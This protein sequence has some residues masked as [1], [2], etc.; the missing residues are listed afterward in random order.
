MDDPIPQHAYVVREIKER[1]PN[2]AFLSVVEPRVSGSQV[3]EQPVAASDSNDFLREIWK[4]KLLI[5]GGGYTRESAIQQAEKYPNELIAFGRQ[6]IS[7]PDL[8]RRL[9]E[10]LPLTKYDRST[11]YTN[12]A[13]GYIDYPFY[14]DQKQGN[15]ITSQFRVLADKL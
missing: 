4:P 12:D 8:F 1:Y 9:R 7:N 13:K 11:F 10:D 3:L 2:F 6:F 14:E 5:S 15:G